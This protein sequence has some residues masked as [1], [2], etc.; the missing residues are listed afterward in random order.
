MWEGKGSKCVTV[1]VM[2]PLDA[3]QMVTSCTLDIILLIQSTE[4]GP[5]GLHGLSVV[6]TAAEVF[7]T[8]NVS[9]TTLSQS[10]GD[11]PVWDHHWSTKNATFSHAQLMEVGLVG[12]RGRNV[13]LH[14]EVGIT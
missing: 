9:V 5:P 2:A 10:M 13:L 8:A 14:V 3:Q 7:G 11:C 6:V 4:P 12:H 1:L